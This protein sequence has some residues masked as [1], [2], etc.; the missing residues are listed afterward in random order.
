MSGKS[1]VIC[2]LAQLIGR[3]LVEFPMNS[4]TDTTEL[5]GGF[6]QVCVHVLLAFSFHQLFKFV[7]VHILRLILTLSIMLTSIHN[8]PPIY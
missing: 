5:L 4:D 7:T 6:Q 1:S 3:K 2:V 8:C